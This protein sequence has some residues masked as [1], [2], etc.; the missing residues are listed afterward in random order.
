MAKA[1]RMSER[2]EMLATL[3]QVAYRGAS[4]MVLEEAL[5]LA[6]RDRAV[7]PD[8][9]HEIDEAVERVVM[10]TE[11]ASKLVDRFYGGA[12]VERADIRGALIRVMAM[13]LRA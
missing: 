4:G 12:G 7:R 9:P 13:T 10:A 6:L 11:D 1:E 3:D 8:W 5:R 2:T